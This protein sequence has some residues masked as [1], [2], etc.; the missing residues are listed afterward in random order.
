MIL[1]DSK[2]LLFLLNWYRI[3]FYPRI[4]DGKY[5]HC[6]YFYLNLKD[7][8]VR[9]SLRFFGIRMEWGYNTDFKWLFEF[10][11]DNGP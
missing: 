11:K 7:R 1:A 6:F 10:R 8:D 5:D 2:H 4:F 9:F 3:C